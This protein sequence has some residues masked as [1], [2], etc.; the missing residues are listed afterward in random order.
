M[1]RDPAYSRVANADRFLP[2]HTAML[3]TIGELESDFEVELMDGY[4]LDEELERGRDLARSDVKL[5]PAGPDAAPFVV[6]FTAFPDLGVRLGRCYV[7]PFP[8]CG[9]DACD[10][11]AEGESERLGELLDD[12]TAGRFREAI[13]IHPVPLG[14]LVGWR[15]GSGHLTLVG[16]PRGLEESLV[17][18]DD[19][20]VRCQEVVIGWT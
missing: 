4:G 11:T 17:L 3:E 6:A 15:P 14:G 9:C 12:M 13:E 7:E 10:E 5:N 2:L 19:G 16:H 20:R 18:K 1:P 8:S